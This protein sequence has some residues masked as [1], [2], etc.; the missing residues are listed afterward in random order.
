M[1]TT[2]TKIGISI[3]QHV[4]RKDLVDHQIVGDWENQGVMRLN[5]DGTWS[6]ITDMPYTIS[7]NQLIWA[8]VTYNRVQGTT[9]IRGIWRFSY[10][11]GE[12][13]DMTFGPRGFYSYIWNDGISGGGYYS[14]D[15]NN[16][17]VVETRGYVTCNGSTLRITALDGVSITEYQY[18]VSVNTLTLTSPSEVITY[19]RIPF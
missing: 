7:N 3:A 4:K 10:S 18:N 8:G 13:V 19:S 1:K 2:P 15:T 17:A 11:S 14:T 9:G 16:L 12:S 6:Y 5:A